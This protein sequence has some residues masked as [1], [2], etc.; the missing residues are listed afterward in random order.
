[1]LVSD[2]IGDAPQRPQAPT[3]VY[4][5]ACGFCTKWVRRAKRL[6]A[7]DHVRTVPRQ[8]PHAILL[9]GQSMDELSRAVHFVRPDGAVFAGAAAVRELACYLRG[10]RLLRLLARAPGMMALAELGYAWVARTWG[11][12]TARLGTKDG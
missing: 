7:R 10:G 2:R 6:D 12:V 4:D 8:D 5:G 11:P 9:T 1:M 3:L